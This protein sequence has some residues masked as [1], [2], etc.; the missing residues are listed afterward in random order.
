MAVTAPV[1]S[2]VAELRRTGG[3]AAITLRRPP[4]NAFD[5]VLVQQLGEL[6]AEVAADVDVRCV[7]FRGAG[8]LFSAGADVEALQVLA[9]ATAGTD[10]V[11]EHVARMQEL[12]T[13]VAGLP[14]PTIAAIHG[15][16]AG[17]GLE[18]ALACDLRIVGRRARLGLPEVG[19]GLVPGAGGTQRI[20][21]QV[22]P[23]WAARLVLGGELISGTEAVRIGLAQ[24]AVP[25]TDVHA[26]VEE[27]AA[28]IAG[29]PRAALVAAKRCLAAA[30][31]APG[32]GIE[33]AAVR[34]LIGSQETTALL[35]AFTAGRS[36]RD[37]SNPE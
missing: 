13:A 8:A 22:G 20:A 30:G 17:G 10:A 27:V 31:T 26:A 19:L 34:E 14:V 12:F 18:L 6:V 9:A 25:D 23:G 5:P 16:A 15:V 32:F 28:R 36:R 2:A 4:A 33:L 37:R 29:R 24:H 1:S 3:V 35:A 7:V 21:R 11:V